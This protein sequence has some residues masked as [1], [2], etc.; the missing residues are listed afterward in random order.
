[1]DQSLFSFS[2]NIEREK[3]KSLTK[4]QCV[5]VFSVSYLAGHGELIILSNNVTW[6][7][8]DTLLSA[9]V[10]NSV[11]N[12]GP[13]VTAAPYGWMCIGNYY[14]CTKSRLQKDLANWQILGTNW[15]R[16][17]W[18]LTIPYFNDTTA[19]FD[20]SHLPSCLSRNNRDPLCV[21]ITQLIHYV[22]SPM[23]RTREEIQH[24]LDNPGNWENSTWAKNI[25][26]FAEDSVCDKV[27]KTAMIFSQYTNHY[28]VDG[29]L[30]VK[31]EEHCQ[32]LFSPL[33]SI[34]V[35]ITNLIKVV[36]IVFIAFYEREPRLLTIGDAI[37]SFLSNPDPITQGRCLSP[38]DDW[39]SEHGH[40]NGTGS[41]VIPRR[42]R[43]QTTR[44]WKSGNVLQWGFTL[45]L[46]TSVCQCHHNA[47]LTFAQMCRLHRCFRPIAQP[48]SQRL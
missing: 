19:S 39:K 37:T 7:D 31:V 28:N 21:D 18:R 4:E 2:S 46:Y 42:L 38:K 8:Q 3:P 22:W 20:S 44:W 10:G 11:N 1:M 41:H 15:S 24:H 32:L 16:T 9:G 33:F 25:D 26:F 35:I 14:T 29:C 43:R 30:S 23:P 36:C 17:E 13:L 6:N 40:W 48:W 45:I 47:M 5:D 34:V 27:D 12:Y